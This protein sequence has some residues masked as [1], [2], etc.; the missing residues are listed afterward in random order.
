MNSDANPAPRERATSTKGSDAQRIVFFDGVCSFCD[1]AVKWLRAHDPEGRLHFASLQGETAG[2]FRR[3]F[4]SDFPESIDSLVYVD[5]SRGVPRITRGSAAV[6]SL[7]DEIGG[8]WAT[9][10]HL[11][12]LPRGLLE[13]FY[14]V[15]AANRYRIFGRLDACAIPTPAE[16]A[17]LL[18]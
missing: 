1:G 7:C 6:L 3:A 18:P 12:V 16:R 11:R 9:V 10:G 4:P 5:R 13:F 14:R 17:R 2:R 15:F 8:A